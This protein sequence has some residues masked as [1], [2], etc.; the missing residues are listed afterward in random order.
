VYIYIYIYN[1][2]NLK[3]ERE[4]ERERER[5]KVI[6][7][8]LTELVFSGLNTTCSEMLLAFIVYISCIIFIRPIQYSEILDTLLTTFSNG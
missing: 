8:V 7:V 4:R 1:A 2:F 5:M 6:C 3:R